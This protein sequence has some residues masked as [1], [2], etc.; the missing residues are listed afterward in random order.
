MARVMCPRDVCPC[1]MYYDKELRWG[2]VHGFTLLP[3]MI[4][5]P[6]SALFMIGMLFDHADYT[7]GYYWVLGFAV[8]AVAFPAL[9]IYGHNRSKYWNRMRWDVHQTPSSAS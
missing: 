8:V 5:S 2:L 1:Q 7:G 3:A 9:T 4:I 6:L